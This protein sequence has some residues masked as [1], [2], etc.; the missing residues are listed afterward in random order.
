[1][2]LTS[3]RAAPP[4]VGDVV[5]GVCVG[6]LDDLAA[7]DFPAPW[8]AVS[9]ALGFFTSEFGMGSGVGTPPKP[10]GRRAHPRW[11]LWAFVWVCGPGACVR[12]VCAC[13][14]PAV[15]RHPGRRNEGCVGCG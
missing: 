15:A 11:A 1:M 12:G 7:T 9:W 10:P 3:Y 8:G 6:G 14:W 4:R 2:S 5:V 13:E